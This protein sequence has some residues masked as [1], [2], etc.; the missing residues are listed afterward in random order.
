MPLAQGACRVGGEESITF[1]LRE[2]FEEPAVVGVVHGRGMRAAVCAPGWG[3]MGG[4]MYWM[5]VLCT[6]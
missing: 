5:I 1:P 2:L 6:D 4:V 3:L